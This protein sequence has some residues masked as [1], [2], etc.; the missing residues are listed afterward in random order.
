MANFI[1][2]KRTNEILYRATTGPFKGTYVRIKNADIL[3]K[4]AKASNLTTRYLARDA[5]NA[6]FDL[7]DSW[8]RRMPE[9]VK[10]KFVIDVS[11]SSDQRYLVQA[12]VLQEPGERR[13]KSRATVFVD[14]SG[15]VMRGRRYRNLR[16]A[17]SIS[18]YV[19]R[20]LHI[21][22][23][24]A[25]VEVREA[26]RERVQRTIRE[27]MQEFGVKMGG[28]IRA[29]IGGIEFGGKYY[30]GGQYLPVRQWR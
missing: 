17:P 28:R 13:P 3:D 21:A 18:L 14:K 24:A 8:S 25:M 29:P 26:S 23:E 5:A 12:T 27:A 7:Y 22:L 19:A 2:N 11:P 4:I 30:K 6:A 16:E 20:E 1:I 15:R 9:P 10:G